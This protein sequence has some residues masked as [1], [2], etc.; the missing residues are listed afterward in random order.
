MMIDVRGS[1]MSQFAQRLSG[2]VDRTVVDKTG[3]AGKFNFH[4]EFTPDPAIP[5][6]NFPGARGGNQDQTTNPANPPPA[7]ESGPDLFVALQEQIGLKLTSDKGS[8]SI[9]I[10]DHAEKPSAN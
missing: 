5:G 6:Q 8:V 10:I 7:P 1:T 9:L 4:L 2:R 3:I